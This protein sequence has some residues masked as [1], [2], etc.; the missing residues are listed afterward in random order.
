MAIDNKYGQVTCEHGSIG[1]DEPVV[2]FR[3]RDVL[4]LDVLAYYRNKC[5]QRNS[6]QK[7]LDLIH[8]TENKIY[9]WQQAHVDLVRV[10][11]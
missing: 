3:A 6:P 2:V 9:S 10:P 8:E 7:H 11:G 1:E 4:L 5:Q